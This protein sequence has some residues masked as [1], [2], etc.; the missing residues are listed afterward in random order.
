MTE[1]KASV[2]ITRLRTTPFSNSTV[3]DN[4]SGV[5]CKEKSVSKVSPI[6]RTVAIPT[7]LA[8]TVCEIQAVGAPR[9]CQA[10][11]ASVPT[12]PLRLTEVSTKVHH[13]R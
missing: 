11:V 12:E 4:Y 7:R 13:V 2:S 1:S 9:R 5:S 8:K 6:G 3:C 10:D